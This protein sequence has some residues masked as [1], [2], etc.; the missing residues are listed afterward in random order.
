MGMPI[1]V[2]IIDEAAN[3]ATFKQVFDYFKWVDDTFST[4]KTTSEITKVNQGLPVEQ[5][6][7]AMKTVLDLCE[8]TK[9]ETKGYFDIKHNG[10]LDPSGIVKGWA[11]KNAAGIL[12][13]QGFYNYYVEA[14][15]DIQVAG[16]RANG[17]PWRVGIRNPFKRDEIIKTVVVAHEGVAT[18]GTAIRGQHIYNPH[19]PNKAINDIVALTVI[20]P[21]IYDADRFATAAFAM[22]LGAAPFIETL[23]GYEAYMITKD[24][25]A[26]FTS[27]FQ[28]Y[29]E[30]P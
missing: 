21:D 13:E 14:G 30:R 3:E 6:S 4:Y 2:E 15:G 22:S 26:I 25:T 5:W 10:V 28:N 24:K 18:S 8:Q 12:A 19:A 1:S 7:P 29:V 23:P 27:G 20:G 11:V 17:E 16:Q 9:Q